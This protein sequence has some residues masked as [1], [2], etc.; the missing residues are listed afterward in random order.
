MTLSG[1]AVSSPGHALFAKLVRPCLPDPQSLLLPGW[2]RVRRGLLAPHQLFAVDTIPTQSVPRPWPSTLRSRPPERPRQKHHP[3]RSLQSSD[4]RACSRALNLFSRLSRIRSPH[5]DYPMSQWRVQGLSSS[6]QPDHWNLCFLRHRQI[7]HCRRR[8]H[9]KSQCKNI[10]AL[11]PFEAR[12]RFC[13]IVAV[14]E[15]HQLQLSPGDSSFIVDQFEIR[16]R[17][18]DLL[19]AKR[20]RGTLERGA[21]SDHN[22]LVRDARRTL[23][24]TQTVSNG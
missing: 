20:L 2:R 6:E 14:V 23:S 18:L 24:H 16:L 1:T 4:I 22:H 12:L 13:G 7:F 15:R 5:I 8:A 3:D 19:R 10:L 21:R 9:K 11:Q 17:A